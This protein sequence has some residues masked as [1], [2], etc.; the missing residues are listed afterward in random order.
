MTRPLAVRFG[1]LGD[2]VLMTVAIQGLSERF[3]SAVDILGSGEWTRPLLQGQPGVG[4]IFLLRSRSRPYWTAPD[5][6]QLVQA[7]RRRGAGPTWLFDPRIEKASWLLRRA[8]WRTDDLISLDELPNVAGEHFCDR[9]RRFAKLTPGST[10]LPTGTAGTSRRVDEPHPQLSVSREATAELNVWL[11]SLGIQER[12]YILI[13]PGNKRTM[14]GGNRRRASNMKYW[15][16]RYWA[17]VL[18]GLRALYPKHALLLLG[19]GPEALINDQILALAK[20]STARNLARGMTVPRL[21]AL[22][23][24]A[25]GMISVDTGPVHVAAALGCPVLTLFDSPAKLAMYAPRGPDAIISCLVGGTDA[26][27]SML[28]IA[29]AAILATW[30]GMRLAE[31][32]A[33]R[34]SA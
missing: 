28:G 8:G 11:R 4:D 29:P 32:A 22:S 26:A 33:R 5:Q 13:Q 25:L 18:R 14:R 16:E 17:E 21:M 1:A 3:G 34:E 30:R 24:G 7:L 15:P 31:I 6:W 19:V 12:H 2:M 27:P 23:A 9:W 20:V 10:M